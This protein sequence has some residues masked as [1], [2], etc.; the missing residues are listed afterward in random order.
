MEYCVRTIQH[1]NAVP[2]AASAAPIHPKTNETQCMHT[3]TTG[4]GKIVCR[5]RAP[6]CA[7]DVEVFAGLNILLR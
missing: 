7:Y 5:V 1:I 4:N 3:P 6:L 2:S